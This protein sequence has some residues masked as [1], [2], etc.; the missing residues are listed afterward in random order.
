VRDLCHHHVPM[1]RLL[2][3]VAE[4]GID[5]MA[6]GNSASSRKVAAKRLSEHIASL[7]PSIRSGLVSFLVLPSPPPHHFVFVFAFVLSL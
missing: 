7:S 1:A 6:M 2:A 4:L 3:A 5:H